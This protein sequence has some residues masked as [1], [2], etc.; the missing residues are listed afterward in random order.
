MPCVPKTAC[1]GDNTCSTGYTGDKCSQCCDVSQQEITVDGV[2]VRNPDCVGVEK[3]FR[4][5]GRC[6]PCPGNRVLLFA[7]MGTGALVAGALAYELRRKRVSV[8]IVAIGVD[9]FQ[10]LSV[11]ADTNA[12]WPKSIEAV[13]NFLS[14][15]SFNLNVAAPE[16]T[17][18]IT[19]EMKWTAVQAAPLALMALILAAS[20]AGAAYKKFVKRRHGKHKVWDHVPQMVGVALLGFYYVYLY[21]SSMS[22]DVFN[23][24]TVVSDDEFEVSDDKYYMKSDPSL[25]CNECPSTLAPPEAPRDLPPL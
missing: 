2:E 3:H 24:G 21:V 13:F 22:L 1:A 6:E 9:Y 7:L 16:C 14:T 11:F 19:Y 25:E 8:A 4:K 18:S 23:C 17:M 15:F 20:V 5:N 12:D 10:V